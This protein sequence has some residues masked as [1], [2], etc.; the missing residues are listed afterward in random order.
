MDPEYTDFHGHPIAV[1]SVVVYGCALGR[2]A[3]LREAEVTGYT[4]SG[5]IKITRPHEDL[6]W[7]RGGFRPDKPLSRVKTALYFPERTLVSPLTAEE[8]WSLRDRE[9][10]AR[11]LVYG[12]EWE[13]QRSET[14]ARNARDL[15]EY[16]A[17]HKPLVGF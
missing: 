17:N 6:Y 3:A 11:P 16:Q 12:P 13:A 4:E 7:G 1:G 14:I 5:A 10:A 2:S 15:R 9:W 8:F